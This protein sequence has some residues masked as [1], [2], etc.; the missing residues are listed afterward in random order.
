[1]ETLTLI[2]SMI[3]GSVAGK[4]LNCSVRSSPEGL[5]L[6][7]G[8][9][10]LRPAARNPVYGMVISIEPTQPGGLG[11]TA[12]KQVPVTETLTLHY[13]KM[14]ISPPASKV[15][16]PAIPKMAG[17]K[18]E[19][20]ASK[21]DAPAG[22]KPAPAIIHLKTPSGAKVGA[23]ASKVDAPTALK[24]AGAKIETPA[25]KVDAPSSAWDVTPA[26]RAGAIVLSDRAI[27]A[28]CLV[29]TAGFGDLVDALQRAGTVT[30][31][32]T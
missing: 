3:R 20:P 5:K 2:H 17:A 21:V 14:G 13:S 12:G 4:M 1:M 9:Y 10:V 6:P 8:Q 27:A 30:L 15:D 31:V 26:V 16:A 25:S 22:L 19:A 11:P 23:P 24:W 7:A 28:N 29:V 32:V 18:I